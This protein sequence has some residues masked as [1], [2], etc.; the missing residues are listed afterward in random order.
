M[1]LTNEAAATAARVLG[2]CCTEMKSRAPWRWNCAAQNG[3]HVSF[4]ASVEEGFLQLSAGT[5]MCGLGGCDLDRALLRNGTLSGGVKYVLDPSSHELRLRA[6]IVI[7]DELQLADRVRL[8][9][10]GLH[11]GHAQLDECAASPAAAPRDHSLNSKAARLTQL[12]SES[13]WSFTERSSN[14]LAV[15]L[16]VDSAPPALIATNG[17]GVEL[18]LELVRCNSRESLR[19]RAV[20]VF[21]LTA[22]GN[23]RLARASSSDRDGQRS[24]GFHVC[25]PASAVAEEVE[26]ALSALSVAYRTCAREAAALLDQRTAQYYLS[27]VG[28]EEGQ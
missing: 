21:L 26:H 20:S 13:C 11:Q 18:I 10:V 7:V 22:N 17:G 23:L 2:K 5:S 6:D 19:L 28:I 15:S 4:D 3:Q 16:R 27:A 14:E 12:L 1:R 8:G 9:L 25:L 24:F